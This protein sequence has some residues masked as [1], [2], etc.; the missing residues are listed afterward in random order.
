[1]SVASTP[2]S[3]VLV[4]VYLS[5]SRKRQ[6]DGVIETLYTAAMLWKLDKY[7]NMLSGKL[8]TAFAPNN[9]F[10]NNILALREGS[11]MIAGTAFGRGYLRNILFK[12]DNALNVVWTNE[13]Y[14]EHRSFVSIKMLE[15]KNGEVLIAGSSMLDNE[16]HSRFVQTGYYLFNVRPGGSLAWSRAY[17]FNPTPVTQ[18]ASLPVTSVSPNANSSQT[19]WFRLLM[20]CVG[21]LCIHLYS[22]GRK[23]VF[24]L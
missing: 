14:D 21:M 13:F 24:P 3:G 18:P 8:L 10:L 17:H 11:Y 1:M 22:R 12:V 19:I 4:S 6:L 23:N 2:D 20:R 9:V 16:D 7:G 5:M 15:R